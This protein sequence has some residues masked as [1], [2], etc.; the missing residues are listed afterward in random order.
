MHLLY[1]YFMSHV[2]NMF[3]MGVGKRFS[4]FFF[5]AA[6]DKLLCTAEFTRVDFRNDQNMLFFVFL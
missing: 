5:Q 1:L 2:Y 3:M 6:A 4:S